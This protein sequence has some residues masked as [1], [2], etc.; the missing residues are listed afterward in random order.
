MEELGLKSDGFMP[1]GG[2]SNKWERWLKAI[3][4]ET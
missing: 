2:Q 4:L 1:H 3:A